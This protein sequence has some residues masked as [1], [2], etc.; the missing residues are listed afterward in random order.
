MKVV[1]T[2]VIEAAIWKLCSAFRSAYGS[3]SLTSYPNYSPFSHEAGETM[4]AF[5]KS[6]GHNSK[7]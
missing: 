2:I 1:A 6:N 5:E 4:H 7:K 3:F